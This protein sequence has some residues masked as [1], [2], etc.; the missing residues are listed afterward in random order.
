MYLLCLLLFK[1]TTAEV[2]TSDWRLLPLQNF[3]WKSTAGGYLWQVTIATHYSL[4]HCNVVYNIMVD[5][6]LDLGANERL[7]PVMKY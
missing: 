5:F 7:K 4:S 1:I 6:L 2:N 3:N